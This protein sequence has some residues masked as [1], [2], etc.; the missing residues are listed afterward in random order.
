MGYTR[1][2]T[3][4]R[5][6]TMA[7]WQ[8]IRR[9]VEPIQRMA[10]VE[11]AGPL[12]Y[13]RPR[14]DNECIAFNG[15]AAT[16]DDYETFELYRVRGRATMPFCKTAK[17][18]YDLAVAAI[19]CAAER[20]APGALADV[21]A[22]GGPEDWAGADAICDYLELPRRRRVARKPS[23]MEK[24]M[25]CVVRYTGSGVFDVV[26]PSG[27]TYTVSAGYGDSVEHWNCTCLWQT[28]GNGRCCAHTRAVEAWLDQEAVALS[29]VGARANEEG[30][31]VAA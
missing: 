2:W 1:Y 16:G 3:Q 8:R 20:L 13:G 19:L 12:G 5:S 6:F 10:G 21:S 29:K 23:V 15:A 9:C 26:S 30:E 31:S 11:L 17:R 27:R 24:A 25:D 4:E 14:A 22:D 18:P 7:E 28:V